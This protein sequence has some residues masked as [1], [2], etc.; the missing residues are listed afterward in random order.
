V[1]LNSGYIKWVKRR[2]RIQWV[3]P[4]L[5]VIALI[6]C[7]P[8][9]SMAGAPGVR[10]SGTYVVKK[11]QHPRSLNRYAYSDLFLL[12][13]GSQPCFD[14]PRKYARRDTILNLKGFLD[15][16][17]CLDIDY[18]IVFRGG[19]GVIDSV[20]QLDKNFALTDKAIVREGQRLTVFHYDQNGTLVDQFEFHY[21]LKYSRKEQPIPSLERLFRL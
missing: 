21:G 16:A 15:S 20:Y 13:A 17:T 5:L 1:T 4:A 12:A 18:R 7:P 2:G 19:T 14:A 6:C 8:L 9:L 10:I 11:D 3:F